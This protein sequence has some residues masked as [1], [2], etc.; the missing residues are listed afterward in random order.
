MKAK[1]ESFK[2]VTGI[3]FAVYLLILTW[4]ILCKMQTDFVQLGKMQYRNINLIPFAGS[5]VKNGKT[6][7]SEILLNIAAFIP[8]GV[9]ISMLCERWGFLKKVIPVLCVSLTYE[10]L[11]YTFGIGASDITDLLGNTFGGVIGIAFYMVL[12]KLFQ[13]CSNETLNKT[14]NVIFAMGT[15]AVVLLLGVLITVNL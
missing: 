14:L 6:D 12:T 10:V 5:L 8:F 11:Q 7:I 1:K 4:I 3:L 9:Y 15:I 2:S 13:N